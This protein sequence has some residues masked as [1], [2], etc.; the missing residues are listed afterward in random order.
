FWAADGDCGCV[1]LQ[2]SGTD[3]E[4]GE[5]TGENCS[6]EAPPGIDPCGPAAVFPEDEDE[7]GGQGIVAG[8]DP[9]SVDPGQEPGEEGQQQED[10]EPGEELEQDPMDQVNKEDTN[11]D[12][13]PVD[14]VWQNTRGLRV[15]NGSKQKMKVFLEYE[16]P[17]DQNQMQRYPQNG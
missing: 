6:I 4:P 12:A 14:S 17:N 9:Q 3:E 10:Q 8:V 13:A 15:A 5:L 11:F 7:P 16:T 2:P 1:P